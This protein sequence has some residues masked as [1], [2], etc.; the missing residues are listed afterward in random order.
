MA[1]AYNT[2]PSIHHNVFPIKGFYIKNILIF[3]HLPPFSWEV[4]FSIGGNI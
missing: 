2:Y 3:V 1:A 4:L